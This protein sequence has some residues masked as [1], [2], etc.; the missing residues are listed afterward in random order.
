M[1]SRPTI[2]LTNAVCA[3]NSKRG[4]GT[5]RTKA[6]AG[7]G[8]LLSIMRCPR[9]EYGEAGCGRVISLM[10]KRELLERTKA[11]IEQV[12]RAAVWP[13]YVAELREQ[14]NAALLVPGRLSFGVPVAPD[15]NNAIRW[16]HDYWA[17]RGPVED[18]DTL[19]CSCSVADADA[20]HCHR[21]EA[22]RWLADAGWRVILDGRDV[23]IV[24]LADAAAVVNQHTTTH[25]FSMV[26]DGEA[27]ALV[28]S[29]GERHPIHLNPDRPK[30]SVLEA[31]A[32]TAVAAGLPTEAIR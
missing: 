11:R 8:R 25:G 1:N 27:W 21:V 22:A 20:G 13:D 28:S 30:E 9:P 15:A 4:K 19:M 2:Y 17:A 26:F 16:D 23:T 24:S 14:W 29:S 10:P 18:G 32:Q 31:L 5:D 3:R 7:P 6:S 12:G